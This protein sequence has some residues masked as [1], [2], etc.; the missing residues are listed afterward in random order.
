ML[1]KK[2]NLIFCVL[3]VILIGAFINIAKAQEQSSFQNRLKSIIGNFNNIRFS[4]VSY[5]ELNDKQVRS[6]KE[7]IKKQ[8]DMEED[9]DNSDPN[10]QGIIDSARIMPLVNEMRRAI[11]NGIR[12]LPAMLRGM[13]MGQL[14]ELEGLF[15]QI[16]PTDAEQRL[17]FQLANPVQR[18]KTDIYRMFIITTPSFNSMQDVPDIIGLVLCKERIDKDEYENALISYYNQVIGNAVANEKNVLTYPELQNFIFDDGGKTTNLYDKLIV[19]YRQGN[20]LPITSEVRGIG[21][22]LTFM[23]TYGKSVSM[24]A[25]ENDITSEDVQNFI[26]ISDGQPFD[27]VRQ[28][29]MIVS[30]DYISWRRYQI[31]YW[32]DEETGTLYPYNVPNSTL[33]VYGMELKF[34]L[35]EI[36]YPSFFSER[37]MVRAI[38]DNIKLGI[39]LPTV[40]WSS[41]TKDV[42]NVDRRFTY[43]GVG[44]SGTFDFPIKVVPQSGVFS[45]SGSYVFGDAKVP[46]YKDRQKRFDNDEFEYKEDD[47]FYNDYLIRY[48]AQAHYT[49]GFSLDES[50]MFRF[51]IGGTLYGAE[52]WCDYIDVNNYDDPIL[53]YKKSNNETVGGLS[54]KVEFMSKDI[55]T[56]FGASLQYFDESLFANL[57]LQIPI[58]TDA[59]FVRFEAKGFAAAFKETLHPWENKAV[60]MPTVRLVFN[61]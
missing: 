35:D 31:E 60:F 1:I 3:L 15:D 22:E 43:A 61:F 54:M 12:T 13:N 17:A 26:R 48:T 16:V 18:I 5:F 50:Y 6:I 8:L 9:D 30:P 52:T 24:I 53:S 36:N 47:L 45:M 38:W 20:F 33:P 41:F 14:D 49:F 46:S 51:G 7:I 23:K 27:Y 4:S 11:G 29:E 56:P 28:N 58:V 59:F 57:W 2:R 19:E 39:V 21:T 34:G 37:M 44:L 25:N 10:N 55:T 40:G 32:E 42:F